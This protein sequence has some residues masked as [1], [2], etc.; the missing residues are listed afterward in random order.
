MAK[1][2]SVDTHNAIQGHSSFYQSK[3]HV[4]LHIGDFATDPA[5]IDH[6]AR[7]VSEWTKD[8][9]VSFGLPGMIRRFRDCLGR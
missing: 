6:Y 9:T 3:G 7:T 8:S 2:V 1:I 5:C 4:Q